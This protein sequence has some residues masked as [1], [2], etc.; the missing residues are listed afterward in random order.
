MI[1]STQVLATAFCRP[2]HG[3]RGLKLR[4]FAI[5]ARKIGRRPPHGGRGLKSYAS[6]SIFST[7]LS[8]SPRR[9]WIEI[10]PYEQWDNGSLKSPSPRRAWIEIY[11]VI[12]TVMSFILS[13]S[14]RRAWIE[15]SF[16]GSFQHSSHVALPTEGV[17]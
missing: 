15:I 9:A 6:V 2:P 5:A 8:P 10:V 3:G 16:I 14:P 12:L 7:S 13:P 4:D 17:D 1:A 11:I